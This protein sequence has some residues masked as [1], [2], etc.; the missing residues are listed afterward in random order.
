MKMA[1]DRVKI[2]AKI[3][4]VELKYFSGIFVL[5]CLLG[6][7]P[8]TVHLFRYGLVAVLAYGLFMLARFLRRIREFFQKPLFL[9]LFLFV[10]IYSVNILLH[11]RDGLF[12]FVT[13]CGQL[14]MACLY[15]FVF[16]L[17]FSIMSSDERGEILYF[18]S[19]IYIFGVLVFSVVSLAMLLFQYTSTREING[20][21]YRFGMNGR[22]ITDGVVSYQLFGIGTSSSILGDMCTVGILMCLV[23]LKM[24]ERRYRRFYITST[25]IFLLTLCAANAFTSI[26][27]L[28]VFAAA[29]VV[30][31]YFTSISEFH[32]S[33]LRKRICKLIFLALGTFL[34]VYVLYYA[35][36]GAEASVINLFERVRVSVCTT[37]EKTGDAIDEMLSRL[38][39]AES[40][41]P[42]TDVAEP[43][44]EPSPE[45]TP[46]PPMQIERKLSTSIYSGRFPIWAA[47][48]Q[49]YVEHPIFGVTNENAGVY[50]DGHLYDNLH[51]AYLMLLVGTGIVGLGLIAI[52]GLALLIKALRYLSMSSGDPAKYLSL[53][54]SICLAIQAGQL[55]NGNFVF[56][57]GESYMFLWMLLGEIYRIVYLQ[58]PSMKWVAAEA[59][60]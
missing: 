28:M 23:S 60:P 38:K 10:A 49:K 20:V 17:Q 18:A 35:V 46:K 52:F 42:P 54:I 7:F 3:S 27:V 59:A 53:L 21:L 50:V 12:T 32:G 41:A 25:V 13:N 8:Y 15:F 58:S 56:A 5:I 11:F 30:C 26:L 33:H 57:P 22:A 16:F 55:V 43:S 44:E 19:R 31:H 37:I 4:P 40:S 1:L 51:N 9:P 39:F 14:T 29:L 6:S 48:L 45:I 36:Q 34:A 2:S 47:A 24:S